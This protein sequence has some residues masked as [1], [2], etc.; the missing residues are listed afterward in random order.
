MCIR[1]LATFRENWLTFAISRSDVFSSLPLRI[2]AITYFIQLCL[3]CMYLTW[4]TS[5]KVWYFLHLKDNRDITL[6]KFFPCQY[7]RYLQYLSRGLKIIKK[8]HFAAVAKLNSCVQHCSVRCFKEIWKVGKVGK[9]GREGL[10][11]P[12]WSQ[13]WL[14]VHWGILAIS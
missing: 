3:R 5:Y 4:V 1:Y 13:L 9:V 11:M 7:S 12:T 2:L 6:G 10:F 8:K 14:P